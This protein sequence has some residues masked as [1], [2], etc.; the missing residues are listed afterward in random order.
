M[1][2]HQ[3][4]EDSA[5]LILPQKEEIS[6]NPTDIQAHWFAHLYEQTE[7]E[8]A[9]VACMLRLVGDV[10]LRMLEIGCG[11]GKLCAPLAQAGHDVTG[12]DADTHMLRYAREKALRLPQL[13]L[14]HGDALTHPWGSG[15]DAVILGSNLLINLTTDW[16]YKQAQKQLI[17]RAADALCPNGLM[18]LDFDCP[19]T[20]A[21]FNTTHEWL[22]ME[23]TDDLGT[24]GRY[25]VCHS[26]ADERTRTVKG[27]RR[28]ELTPQA[29]VPF[30]ATASSTK[31]FPTLEEVCGWLYRAGFTIA[32][33]YGG[34]NGEAFDT[35][36][37]RAVI[38]AHKIC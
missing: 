30:T 28:F 35:R 18:V 19:E 3:Y 16:D 21:H 24:H 31:H 11:G 17:F 10:P 38:S 37:R 13:H 23:G 15:Y 26:T 2:S 9:L 22:C 6:L 5:A 27:Q 1:E 20:L 8:T 36:H 14:I 25:Y 32:S 29:G 34:H 12:M 4:R 33:I 7:D